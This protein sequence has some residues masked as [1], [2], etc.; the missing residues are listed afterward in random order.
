MGKF[1]MYLYL[2]IGL[3]CFVNVYLTV[4][5]QA[6]QLTILMVFLAF[7]NF[8]LFTIFRKDVKRRQIRGL[9]VVK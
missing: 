1:L 4:Q 6:Y 5:A 2:V 8:V 9:H 3:Y 7:I